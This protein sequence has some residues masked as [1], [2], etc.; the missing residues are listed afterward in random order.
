VAED[1]SEGNGEPLPSEASHVRRRRAHRGE[2]ERLR[3][4]ILTAATR[5]LVEQGDEGSVSIRDIADSVGVT[6]PSIYRHFADKDSLFI[7]VG[8]ASMEELLRRSRAAAEGA[9]DPLEEMG[10]RGEAYIHFALDNPDHYR[11]AIPA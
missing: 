3:E 6:P 4:E 7:A 2:G 8:T 9:A 1:A 5:L 10:R 11:V